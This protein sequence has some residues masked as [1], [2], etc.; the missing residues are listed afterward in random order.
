MIS[1]LGSFAE[2]RSIDLCGA[3]HRLAVSCRNRA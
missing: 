1:A 3:C 2:A